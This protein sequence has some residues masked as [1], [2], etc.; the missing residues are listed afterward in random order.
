MSKH[1]TSVIDMSD[2]P[3]EL[4][5]QI[6]NHLEQEDHMAMHQTSVSWRNMLIRYL[7]SKNAI[8]PA[9]W[10]WFCHHL[11]QKPGCSGCLIKIQ[12]KV[13]NRDLAKDWNWWL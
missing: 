11:P 4:Q 7:N 3:V 12:N 8:R 9:D 6:L 13:D 10:R 1:A 5:W 2:L